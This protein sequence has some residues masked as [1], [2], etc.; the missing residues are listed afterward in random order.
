MKFSFLNGKIRFG[1]RNIKVFK[2]MS[3]KR[4]FFYS[5]LGYVLKTAVVITVIYVIKHHSLFTF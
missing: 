5:L 2:R 4:F 3:Y 1:R